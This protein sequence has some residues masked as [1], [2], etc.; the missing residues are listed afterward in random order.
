MKGANGTCDFRLARDSAI[1]KSPK[2]APIQKES[3]NVAK[4]ALSPTTNP[5]PRASLTSPKPIA[6]P[7]EKSHIKK[8]GDA[9]TGPATKN[10]ITVNPGTKIAFQKIE[11]R[12]KI[13]KG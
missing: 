8:N 11:I 2:I 5:I 7:L 1:K 4:D 12:E 9:K 13:I 6:E 10:G 3:K